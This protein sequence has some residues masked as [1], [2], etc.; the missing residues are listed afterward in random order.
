MFS[1]DMKVITKSYF[2]FCIFIMAYLIL[3]ILI[4]RILDAL[5]FS[6]IRIHNIQRLN[7][8]IVSLVKDNDE[9]FLQNNNKKSQKKHIYEKFYH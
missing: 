6:I 4:F 7:C 9:K 2:F 3:Q 5:L 1:F 8:Y